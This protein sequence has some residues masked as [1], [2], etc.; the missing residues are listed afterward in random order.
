MIGCIF[1]LL[2]N[3]KVSSFL[4]INNSWRSKF[5]I[6]FLKRWWGLNISWIVGF[7]ILT[8]IINILLSQS[9]LFPSLFLFHFLFLLL[10]FSLLFLLFKINGIIWYF[11]IQ[12]NW[13]SFVFIRTL[14]I[15][16]SKINII[17][18]LVVEIV[19][20]SLLCT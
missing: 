7:F 9:L 16:R 6:V 11:M 12:I 13:I 18:L 15:F 3:N 17:V 19:I 1:F 2:F 5:A 8:F 20:N 10:S 4:L 14:F